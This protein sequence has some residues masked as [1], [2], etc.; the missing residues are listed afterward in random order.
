M[1]GSGPM[2]EIRTTADIH[3]TPEKVWAVLTDFGA[4]SQW[5]P[6]ITK[7]SGA[8]QPGEPLQL[9][10]EPP[11]SHP[12]AL[13]PTLLEADPG[14]ELRWHGRLGF[15]GLLEAYHT[16]SLVNKGTNRTHVIARTTF[17]GPFVGFYTQLIDTN[18]REGFEG[19]CRALKARVQGPGGPGG[20]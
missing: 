3:S 17:T 8:L 9:Q 6:F 20:T 16:V 15:L 7:A 13:Q 4:Y 14:R 12:R 19:M 11:G 2:K 5:N 18:L 10:L 1:T